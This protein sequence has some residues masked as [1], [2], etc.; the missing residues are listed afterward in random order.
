[1][2]LRLLPLDF[3]QKYGIIIIVNNKE[4]RLKICRY[5]AELCAQSSCRICPFSESGGECGLVPFREHL[6][7][8][9]DRNFEVEAADKYADLANQIS[10]QEMDIEFADFQFDHCLDMSCSDCPFTDEGL[11]KCTLYQ[12]RNV[13]RKRLGKTG[14]AT[15]PYTDS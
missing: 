5:L 10:L 11:T 1:M 3:F 8:E 13:L 15:F 7:F 2:K 4:I 14:M 9:N 6:N 12:I